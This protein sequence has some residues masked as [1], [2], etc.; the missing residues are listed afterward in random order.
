MPSDRDPRKFDPVFLHARREALVILAVWVA[1]LI[2]SMSVYMWL[3]YGPAAEGVDLW[4]GI[5]RWVVIG[6]AL[7]WLAADLFAAWFCFFY[8]ADDD[9]GE[10]REG[11]DLEEEV[12]EIRRDEAERRDA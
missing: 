3:G 4:W 1:C 2:W 11:L 6:I 7:P 9:L 12:A 5:P 10:A 8:M